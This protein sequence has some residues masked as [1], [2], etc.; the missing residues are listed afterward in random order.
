MHEARDLKKVFIIGCPR[1]GTT[2]VQLLMA[3]HPEVATAPETQIFA[4]YLDHFQRQW[5]HEQEGPGSKHQGPV[6]LSRVLSP[7]EFDE[8]CG[9]TAG[10][11]FDKI[12]QRNPNATVLAEKSPRHALQAEFIQRVFPDAYF[13]HVIRD[14]RDTAASLLA[15]GRSWAP[16]APK[17][18]I[19][20]G[21][22]WLQCV[23]AARRIKDS[24]RYLELR[25][26]S[27]SS[28]PGRE[29][30][31]VFEWLGIPRDLAFC[32]QAVATCEINKLKKTSKEEGLPIPGEKNPKDFFRNGAVGGW[33]SELTRGEIRVI[34]YICREAMRGTGYDLMLNGRA[35]PLRLPLHDALQRVR[36]SVD[37]QLQKLLQK[38]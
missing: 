9:R 17:N 27:L 33:K 34:E 28:A 5:R 24:D 13:L 31:A 2:W 15:A 20:A 18:A 30:Q 6:G 12:A 4:Y 14:P 36:E 32:D 19:D 8:M 23:S 3:Q 16:W 10:I 29:L 1:S 25:Y 7:T 26:E 22:L 38:V 37:W 21:R 35:A 11:V